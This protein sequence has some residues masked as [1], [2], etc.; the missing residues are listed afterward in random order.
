M[1]HTVEFLQDKGFAKAGDIQLV[2][3]DKFA[4]LIVEEGVIREI[5]TDLSVELKAP[6]KNLEDKPTKL[7][8]KDGDK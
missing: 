3:A 6:E 7:T 2:N 1:L 5:I 4:S 8:S